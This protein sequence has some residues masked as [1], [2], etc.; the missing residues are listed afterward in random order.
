MERDFPSGEIE[1]DGKTRKRSL[2]FGPSLESSGAGGALVQPATRHPRLPELCLGEA[3]VQRSARPVRVQTEETGMS[4]SKSAKQ[5]VEGKDEPEV[6]EVVTESVDEDGDVIVDDLV[7]EVDSDGHVMATDETT[8][9][10]TAEGDVVVDETFSV[11]GEDGT[12]HAVAED[13][14]VVEAGG[15]EE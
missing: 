13:V 15:P 9:I 7:A 11:A 3:D 10:R 5:P 1:R 6:I 4:D 12:L 2:L 14:T 8:L